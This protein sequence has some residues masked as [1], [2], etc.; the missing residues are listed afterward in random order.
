[1][2]LTDGEEFDESTRFV[3]LTQLK[4]SALRAR[5]ARLSNSHPT[6]GNEANRLIA[7]S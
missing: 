6:P 7:L 2:L 4:T 3:A 5:F 1:M